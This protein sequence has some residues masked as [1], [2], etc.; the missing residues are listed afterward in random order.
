[1]LMVCRGTTEEIKAMGQALIGLSWLAQ[2]HD[3]WKS[4]SASYTPAGVEGI[5]AIQLHRR[6]CAL[7]HMA[8]KPSVT[9]SATSAHITNGNTAEMPTLTNM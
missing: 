6:T 5:S 9:S 3:A 7:S 2:A 4:S 1:M 8:W